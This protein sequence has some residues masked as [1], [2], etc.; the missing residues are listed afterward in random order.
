LKNKEEET[1]QEKEKTKQ[2]LI[3]ALNSK[4]ISEDTLRLML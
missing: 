2:M 1:K 3:Q 4:T